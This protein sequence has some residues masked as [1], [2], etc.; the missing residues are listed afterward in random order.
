MLPTI[1]LIGRPNVGKSTLF[2]RLLRKKR[3]ITHDMPGITRDRIYAEGNFNGV[4]YALIDTGGLVMESDNDS[5]EF[6]GDIFDQARE[7]I[8]ESHALILVVDGRTGMTPLDEQVAAYI[9]QSNKPILLLVNKVDGAEI[10]AQCTADFHCLGFEIM[11]VSAE[12]GFNLLEL[13]EKVAD[14]A[15]ATGIEPE[16][17]ED[18]EAKG[19]KIAMLGRPNAGKSSMVNALTGETRVIVSDIA[20]TTRDSVDVTF[21]SG[22]KVYTFVDTAGVRRRTNITDTIE[23]FSVVRALRSS[24]KADI[25]IMVVDAIAG[26]TKQDKRLLEY[27]LREAVPFIITVNKIDLVS[28]QERTALREG[29]ERALRM[30]HHVPVVYTSCISKSGLGGILALASRLKKECSI[31]I[32]TGQLNRIMKDIVE[33]HQPPVVKRRRAKFK[34]ITQADEE[35]PTFIFFINDEKLIKPTYHRFLENRLRKL[36]NVKNAPLNVVF[37]STFR[38]KEDIVHK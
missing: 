6:Q 29:F 25:T 33:K 20:G 27:L 15:L 5:E 34:Y 37:R 14:M 32:S 23:R 28:K 7:A 3:A 17:E 4:Q 38:K 21:E 8:E 1:A 16:D 36:L 22:G 31:R 19:L 24:T 9:R 35:P 26:I 10:E 12:H 2:N 30:A 11:P 18:E 13:R